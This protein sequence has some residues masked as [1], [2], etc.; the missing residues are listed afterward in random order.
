MRWSNGIAEVG[1]G[2]GIV[3]CDVASGV[4]DAEARP[5]VGEVWSG[6]GAAEFRV[7]FVEDLGAGGAIADFEDAGD[8]PVLGAIAAGGE[9]GA[10]DVVD[11]LMILRLVTDA[12]VGQ[13]PEHRAAPIGAAPGMGVVE[14]AVAR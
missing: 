9:D 13:E 3:E 5:E 6:G 12:E 10:D 8:V 2:G 1:P 4:A 11:R 7:K 14:A